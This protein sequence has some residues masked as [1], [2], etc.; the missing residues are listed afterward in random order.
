MSAF[1]QYSLGLATIATKSLD[2]E[3]SVIIFDQKPGG[4]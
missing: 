2:N 1:P 4:A 3:K